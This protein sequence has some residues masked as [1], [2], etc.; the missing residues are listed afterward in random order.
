MGCE[1]AAWSSGAGEG[2]VGTVRSAG[3]GAGWRLVR[4]GGQEAEGL[5]GMWWGLESALRAEVQLSTPFTL[6][7]KMARDAGS[8][9]FACAG[10]VT[11][12]RAP[13][14]RQSANILTPHTPPHHATEL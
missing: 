1:G 10:S 2:G 4:W 11:G 3:I 8:V 14:R 7:V 13:P 9:G 12:T 5:P 6:A